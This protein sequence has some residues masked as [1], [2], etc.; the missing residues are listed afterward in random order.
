MWIPLIT[1]SAQPRYLALVD[2]IAHAISCGE[3]KPGERLP[4][5]RRLAWALGWNPSTTMQAYREAA[6]RHLVSGEV[7][8][9]TY[10]LSGSREATLFRLQQVD[11][12][13]GQI[14]SSGM[15]LECWN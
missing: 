8:R 11:E 5:Q 7:G 6:R 2:A 14:E 15:R 3:L 4:P 12:H 1:D 9:G 13:A 10:V